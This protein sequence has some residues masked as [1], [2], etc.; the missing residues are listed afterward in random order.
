MLKEVFRTIGIPVRASNSVSSLWYLGLISFLTNWIRL[1]LSMCEI[2]G[3]ISSLPFLIST[4]MSMYSM[5]DGWP[6]FNS[7]QS[8]AFSLRT[9][10]QS[11][12]KISLNFT[13]LFSSSFM[14][15]LLGSARMLLFPSA[16]GP[17][18]ILP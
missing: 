6:S 8:L 4:A 5:G 11:G 12:L 2:A 15:G 10:G 3:T 14:T 1:V 17:V 13:F 7:N 16:R 18:S 9:L